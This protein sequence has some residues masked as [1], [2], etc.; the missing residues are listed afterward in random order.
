MFEAESHY[1]TRHL[2]G[3]TR[4]WFILLSAIAAE[5]AYAGTGPSTRDLKKAL[6]LKLLQPGKV[7]NA[8]YD[9][10]NIRKTNW[11]FWESGPTR[12]KSVLATAHTVINGLRVVYPPVEWGSQALFFHGFG[13]PR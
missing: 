11:G 4:R 6:I 1:S 10:S 3:V 12:L 2:I 5:T 9:I 13:T 8:R 7:S